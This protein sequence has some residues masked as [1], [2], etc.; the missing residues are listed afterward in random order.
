MIEKDIDKIAVL[1]GLACWMDE[2]ETEICWYD[3]A[4]Y[5]F[6]RG[7]EEFVKQELKGNP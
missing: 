1:A 3:G 6:A 5:D 4:G 7:I 2:A